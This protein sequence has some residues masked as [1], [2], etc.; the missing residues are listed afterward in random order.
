[1]K[2][3]VK[4]KVTALGG[5]YIERSMKKANDKRYLFGLRRSTFPYLLALYRIFIV[6]NK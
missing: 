1:M 3:A 2:N 4:M 6:N 5:R